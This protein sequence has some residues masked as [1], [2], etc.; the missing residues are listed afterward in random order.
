[1]KT[2]AVLGLLAVAVV[3]ATGFSWVSARSGSE[4]LP[5][6]QVFVTRD[7]SGNACGEEERFFDEQGNLVKV[8]ERSGPKPASPFYTDL[9]VKPVGPDG[10]AFTF[11]YDK[12]CTYGV[13]RDAQGRRREYRY[14]A[15]GNLV[16]DAQDRLM[17]VEDSQGRV[18]MSFT[19]DTQGNLVKITDTQAPYLYDASAP[20]V[21]VRE[22]AHATR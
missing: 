7:A 11:R 20:L 4:A 12:N 18:Q 14:D 22:D 9:M 15:D 19:Y 10:K 5:Y 17:A 8:V 1:M 6:S 13:Q 3:G 21:A 16:Y 2:A